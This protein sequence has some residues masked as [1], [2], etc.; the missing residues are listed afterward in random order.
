MLVDRCSGFIRPIPATLPVTF[1]ANPTF[2]LSQD[3]WIIAL[4]NDRLDEAVSGTFKRHRTANS[5]VVSGGAARQEIILQRG[6]GGGTHRA[7]NL[8][9]FRNLDTARNKSAVI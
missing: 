6:N 9:D 3:S 8:L 4:M 7:P 2:E 1:P 5:I